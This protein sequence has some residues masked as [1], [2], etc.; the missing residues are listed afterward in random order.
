MV[1]LRMQL[2][3][4]F[5]MYEYYCR[6]SDPDCSGKQ[7]PDMELVQADEWL[8]HEVGKPIYNTTHLGKNGGNRCNPW[9]K[10]RGGADFS[11]HIFNKANDIYVKG[12]GGKRLALIACKIEA[13]RNGGI[14]VAENHIH[15]DVRKSKNGV[16]WI[17]KSAKYICTKAEIENEKNKWR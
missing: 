16:V 4:H 1:D 9:N 12:M 17:Y 10:L 13:F 7:P 6:C 14:G 8:R 5:W 11:E 2:S 15:L 3:E